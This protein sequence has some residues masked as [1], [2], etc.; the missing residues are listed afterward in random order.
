MKTKTLTKGL[1]DL[2][3]DISSGA[4]ANPAAKGDRLLDKHQ[5]FVEKLLKAVNDRKVISNELGE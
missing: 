5:R 3:R 4:I 2:L 1:E